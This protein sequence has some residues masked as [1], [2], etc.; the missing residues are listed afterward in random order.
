MMYE[1]IDWCIVTLDRSLI[2]EGLVSIATVSLIQY[3]LRF[4]YI[5]NLELVSTGFV[6]CS[7]FAENMVHLLHCIHIRTSCSIRFVVVVATGNTCGN[8]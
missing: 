8:W 6:T 7:S 4:L 2:V 1:R 3:L 5:D